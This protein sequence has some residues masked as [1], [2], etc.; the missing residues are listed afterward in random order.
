MNRLPLALLWLTL[1]SLA[2]AQVGYPL[3]D[4]LSGALAPLGL[5]AAP[6]G[7][8]L[9]PDGTRLHLETRGYYLTRATVLLPGS[10]LTQA[11]HYLGA[12]TGF[13]DQITAPF[14]AY[15]KQNSAGLAQGLTVA[16]DQFS[17]FVKQTGGRLSLTVSLSE[18]PAGRFDAGSHII[19]DPKAPIVVREF[20]D[21]QCPYCRQFSAQ[22]LPTLLAK[23][24]KDVRLEYHH[25]PLEQIHP[26]AR[27][28]AE[29]AECAGR[30]GKFF[31]FHDALFASS[32]WIGTG[33]TPGALAKV[34]AQVGLNQ[35]AYAA[36]MAARQGKA[37]VDAGL[38]EGERVGV[39]GTPTL[40]VNGYLVPDP[41]D[42]QDILRLIDLARAK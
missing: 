23:L 1:T 9:A 6:D 22:T 31:P 38:R 34:A 15:L 12:V 32:A 18:V 36:C 26:D 5:K 41:Y 8:Q 17:I 28:A 24:P 3:K 4:T 30:Q 7:D 29:A 37:A 25:F 11:G 16:A 19:G 27:P 13:G 35:S 42:P 39:N 2:S 40:Y 14:A 33:D 10:D 21:F 20:S